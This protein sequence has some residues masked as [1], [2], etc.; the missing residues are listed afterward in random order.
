MR[1]E[2][3]WLVGARPVSKKYCLANPPA[4]AN[5]RTL[6]ATIKARRICGLAHQQ[7]KEEPASATSKAALGEVFIVT[8]QGS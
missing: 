7:L 2:E 3:V 1:G 4:D 6:A 5:L 8:R